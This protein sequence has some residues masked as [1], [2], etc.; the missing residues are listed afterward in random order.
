MDDARKRVQVRR[1]AEDVM[2]LAGIIT[3]GVIALAMIGL[4][5]WLIATRRDEVLG[6]IIVMMTIIIGIFILG[7][8][9]EGAQ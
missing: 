7:L 6:L 2:I 1:S 4:A 8:A 3:L 9:V 5:A